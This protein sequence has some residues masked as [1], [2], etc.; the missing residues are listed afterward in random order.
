MKPLGE[1]NDLSRG[2]GGGRRMAKEGGGE[3]RPT[4]F[5]KEISKPKKGA[6]EDS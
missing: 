4:V 6:D 5:K 2:K 1:K 3:R